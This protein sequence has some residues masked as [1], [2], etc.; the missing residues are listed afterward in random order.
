M[1][2]THL[3][4]YAA[5]GTGRERVTKS[6]RM[7]GES[8]GLSR[9]AGAAWAPAGSACGFSAARLQCPGRGW[10]GRGRGGRRAPPSLPFGLDRRRRLA[11]GPGPRP[12][13]CPPL[14]APPLVPPGPPPR[15]PWGRGPGA[16]TH[17]RGSAPR[18]TPQRGGESAR[19]REGVGSGERG[20]GRAQAAARGEEGAGPGL[21]GSRRG[22]GEAGTRRAHFPAK[23]QLP[24]REFRP[25][26][27]WAPGKVSGNLRF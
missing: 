7:R 25:L 26:T 20:R 21:G 17:G 5:P 16:Q 13:P 10:G 6:S 22:A 1:I 2:D 8:D 12:R 19:A 24:G 14:A 18:V 27:F 3:E 23:C 15:R 9:R 11:A 4:N